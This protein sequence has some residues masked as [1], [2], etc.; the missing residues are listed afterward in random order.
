M[1]Q[2]L[3]TASLA[4]KGRCCVL[5]QTSHAKFKL[6]FSRRCKSS[7][8]FEK[9]TVQTARSTSFSNRR[10]GLYIVAT[11]LLTFTA[12]YLAHRSQSPAV[13]YS[14]VSKFPAPNYATVKEMEKVSL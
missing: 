7:I 12:G 6:P 8:S 5:R 10:L 9:E 14:R 11:G 4:A 13:D 1:S 3:T 2:V